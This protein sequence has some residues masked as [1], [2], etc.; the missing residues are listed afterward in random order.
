[1]NALVASQVSI[2]LHDDII[3]TGKE[4]HDAILKHVIQ[5]AQQM[6]VKLNQ[7]KTSSW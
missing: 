3:T 4:E 6:D 5:R 1:M 7:D 2:L